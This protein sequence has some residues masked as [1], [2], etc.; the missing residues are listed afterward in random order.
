[1]MTTTNT[2]KMTKKDFFN[3]IKAN[4]SL[5]SEEIAFID[6]EIELLSRKSSSERKPSARQLEN[7][8]LK[9]A[10][11]A[12]MADNTMYTIGEMLKGFSCFSEDMT[13]QR[14]SALISQLVESGDVK[15]DMEKRKA[16]FT[17]ISK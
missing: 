8:T 5:T 4:Y 1:M 14:L 10:I 2:T 9:T 13:S 3:Q 7:E 17:R 12:E 11:L 15:R 6:H 16:Y